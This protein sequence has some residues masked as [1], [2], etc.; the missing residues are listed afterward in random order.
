MKSE[1]HRSYLV[2]TAGD[3]GLTQAR[4]IIRRQWY[5][6]STICKEDDLQKVLALSPVF[7]DHVLSKATRGYGKPGRGTKC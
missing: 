2:F 6:L 3:E 7:A 5:D 4:L 1:L